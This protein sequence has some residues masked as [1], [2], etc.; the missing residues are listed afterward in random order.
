MGGR[1]LSGSEDVPGKSPNEAIR[2]SVAL[3]RVVAVRGNVAT[4]GMSF[5]TTETIFHADKFNCSGPATDSKPVTN[6]QRI[7]EAAE[8]DKTS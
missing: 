1:V 4:N 3:R 6:R 5:H 8:F 2:R 7:G